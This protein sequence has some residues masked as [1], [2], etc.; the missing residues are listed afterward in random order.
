MSDINENC[1]H[2]NGEYSGYFCDGTK[3]KPCKCDC[4]GCAYYRTERKTGVGKKGGEK[5]GS[6]MGIY[7]NL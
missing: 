6:G 3:E 7:G 1:I 4:Q 2:R 5:I